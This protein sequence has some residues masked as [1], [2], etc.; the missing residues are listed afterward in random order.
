MRQRLSAARGVSTVILGVGLA[1][2]A[3]LALWAVQTLN[4][5]ATARATVRQAVASALRADVLAAYQTEALGGGA[6]TLN[7]GQAAQVLPALLQ[8]AWPGATVTATGAAAWTVT[9]PPGQAT[10]LDLGPV[11]LSDFQ[12]TDTPPYTVTVGGA[13]T[14]E[15]GPALAVAAAAPFR[16][17]VVGG[18][19][20]VTLRWTIVV[21]VAAATGAGFQPAS[22]P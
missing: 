18:A 15:P 12:L 6:V 14:P 3:A 21:P 8:S 22:G 7:A 10:A 9:P 1:V 17:P 19:V 20:T 4:A 11:T 5:A 13:P 2:W 16:I